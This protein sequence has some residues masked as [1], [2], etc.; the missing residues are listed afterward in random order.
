M[1]A[2]DGLLADVAGAILDGYARRLGHRPNRARTTRAP[3]ARSAPQLSAVADLHRHLPSGVGRRKKKACRVSRGRRLACTLERG[4]IF[5]CSSG[6]ARAPSAKSFAPGTHSSTARSLSSFCP[7]QFVC[8]RPRW[9]LYHRRR[10]P[11]RRACA[12]RTSSRFTVPSRLSDRVGLWMEFVRGHTLA[13]V[14]S[15]RGKRSVLSK[16]STSASS[17]VSAISAVHAAGLLHR[18]IKAHNVM[19]AEDGRVVLMDFGT[20]LE[21]E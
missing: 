7:A 21:L 19:L 13:A 20:G 1:A 16:S 12:M 15:N 14:C 11:A 3:C 6:S 2:S 5:V 18:D 10:P 4:D 17:S 8:R 9:R